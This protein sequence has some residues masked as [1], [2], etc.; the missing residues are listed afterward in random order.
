[1]PCFVPSEH[2]HRRWHLIRSTLGNFPY[3]YF[4]ERAE[5][6][7]D[8]ENGPTEGGHWVRW[9][10]CGDFPSLCYAVYIG[11]HIDQASP[12]YIVDERL[13]PAG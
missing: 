10:Y 9:G 5:W 13:K 11:P 12:F 3:G 2:R 1:M 8:P 7:N 4:W 6:V